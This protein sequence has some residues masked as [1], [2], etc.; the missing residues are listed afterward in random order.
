MFCVFLAFSNFSWV[1]NKISGREHQWWLCNIYPWVPCS[2]PGMGRRVEHLSSL[3]LNLSQPS[4]SEKSS[5]SDSPLQRSNWPTQRPTKTHSHSQNTELYILGTSRSEHLHFEDKV[6]CEWLLTGLACF[7]AGEALFTVIWHQTLCGCC[8]T[9]QLLP[10]QLRALC[11]PK[12]RRFLHVSK[13]ELRP[14]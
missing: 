10:Q 2:A 4:S 14:K 6:A 8:W 5:Q 7:F 13:T 1:W 12:L 3:R 11:A 9:C